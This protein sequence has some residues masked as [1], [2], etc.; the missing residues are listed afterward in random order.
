[1]AFG[2]A[3]QAVKRTAIRAFN[4]G[5]RLYRQKHT[6]MAVPRLVLRTAAMQRQIMCGDN[7]FGLIGGDGHNVSVIFSGQKQPRL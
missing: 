6:R 2:F 4:G 5:K 3:V 1:M 7:D